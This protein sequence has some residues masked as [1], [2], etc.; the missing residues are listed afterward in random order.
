MAGFKPPEL[1]EFYRKLHARGLDLSSLAAAVG[2][3]TCTVSR[4]I[5]GSRRRGPVWKKLQTVLLPEEIKL[6]DVA[7]SS[8]W[9]THRIARQPRWTPEL[10]STLKVA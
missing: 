8:T 1:S 3:N 9:N 2:R 4:V 7:K 5:N 6:L 10:A